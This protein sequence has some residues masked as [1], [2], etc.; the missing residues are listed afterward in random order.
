VDRG[1]RSAAVGAVRIVLPLTGE[2]VRERQ[3]RMIIRRGATVGR[4]VAGGP[5][6][7]TPD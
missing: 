4:F 3:R 1:I 2:K 7:T 5:P 6:R